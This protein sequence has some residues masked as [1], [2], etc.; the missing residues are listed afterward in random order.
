MD[1]KGKRKRKR[2]DAALSQTSRIPS[3]K[4]PLDDQPLSFSFKHLDSDNAKFLLDSCDAAFYRALIEKI[5][6]YSS[7]TIEQFCDENGNDRRHRIHFPETSEPKGFSFLA[8][9]QLESSEIW[10]FCLDPM[11]EWRVHGF[12]IY[13]TFFIVWLDPGHRLFKK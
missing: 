9:E 11:K 4:L 1:R 7:W 10:Q 13:N 2:R 8:N 12:I 5:K 3:V 6:D